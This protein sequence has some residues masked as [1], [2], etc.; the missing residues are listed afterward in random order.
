MLE[1]TLI[2]TVLV[3][4]LLVN[5][6]G[7]VMVAFLLPGTWVILGATTA[8]SIWKWG[9]DGAWG[10]IS[11]WV[12]LLLLGL[13]LFGELLEFAAGLVGA[14]QAGS[15]KRGMGLAL[16]GGIAGAIV[17]TFVIPVPIAGTL[18]GAALGSGVG[19]FGG[20]LWA[21]RTVGLAFKGGKGAAIGR[22][23]GSVAKVVVA[24]LMW[25][26]VVAGILI[27]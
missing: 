17:G 12:L 14:G 5:T 13:A 15:S 2:I 11:V 21:G 10:H 1:A 24:V 19:A 20:D 26:V 8:V 18:I 3:G 9:Q 25:V 23:L 7:V 4:L 16:V 27:G 22:L 6:L